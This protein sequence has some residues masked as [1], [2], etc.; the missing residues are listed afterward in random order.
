MKTLSATTHRWGVFLSPVIMTVAA[1][2]VSLIQ[3][4]DFSRDDVR[5]LVFGSAVALLT[6]VLN[7]ARSQSPA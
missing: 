1:L 5:T 6:L 2:A 7:W 3:D 4:N